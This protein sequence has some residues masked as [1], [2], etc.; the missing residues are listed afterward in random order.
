MNFPPCG[1]NYPKSAFVQGM[2][3]RMRDRGYWKT[4]KS[5]C[6]DWQGIKSARVIEMEEQPSSHNPQLHMQGSSDLPDDPIMGDEQV[7]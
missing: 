7:F 5:S 6:P 4:T 3:T 1:T 2:S